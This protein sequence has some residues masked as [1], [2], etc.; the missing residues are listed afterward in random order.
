MG[1]LGSNAHRQKDRRWIERPGRARRTGG[2]AQAAFAEQ[3]ENRFGLESRE[4]DV[5]RVPESG[6]REVGDDRVGNCRDDRLLE[7]IAH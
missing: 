1:D 3:E 5:G 2:G 6:L 7:P 4:G